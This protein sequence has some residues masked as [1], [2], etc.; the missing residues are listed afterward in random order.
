MSLFLAVFITRPS[1][2]AE[3]MMRL[4]MDT[5]LNGAVMK[6]TCSK[7]I[8]FHTYEPM[9]AWAVTNWTL[10]CCWRKSCPTDCNTSETGSKLLVAV[11]E[12]NIRA[13]KTNLNM[14]DHV[15]YIHLFH[16]NAIQIIVSFPVKIIYCLSD[17]N[18]YVNE[19]MFSSIKINVESPVFSLPAKNFI[20]WQTIVIQMSF[21]VRFLC[22]R[23]QSFHHH[24]PQIS[25]YAVSLI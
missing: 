8:H 12:V 11:I 25:D 10:W 5:S 15:Q 6:I 2:I 14:P 18:N 19:I 17:F 13:G 24:P 1:L 9:S 21:S 20:L 23:G 16:M 4:I 3:G 22:V 7:G